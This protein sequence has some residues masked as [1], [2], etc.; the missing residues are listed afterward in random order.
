MRVASMPSMP[1][2]HR[3]CRQAKRQGSH[4]RQAVHLHQVTDL[5]SVGYTTPRIHS[6]SRYPS[7]TN[8]RHLNV[9]RQSDLLIAL[10][11]NQN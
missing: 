10:R 4:G 6:T 1:S 2:M 11:I 5:R 8:L 3:Y 9:S 7:A